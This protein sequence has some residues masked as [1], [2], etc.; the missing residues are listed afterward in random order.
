M[1]PIQTIE[2]LLGLLRRR[3]VMIAAI[4]V[5]GMIV[6]VLM[7]LNRPKTYETGAVLQVQLPVVATEDPAAV[8]ARTAQ[9]LQ[10]IEQRL[11]T[12]ENLIAIIER[13]D[14]FSDAPGLSISQKVAALRNSIGFQSVASAAQ[15][16]FGAPQRV[17][18]LII[19]A[20]LGDPDKAARLANDLA[21][22]VL[23]MSSARQASRAQETLRF[24]M[25]EDQRTGAAITALE[26][27]IT[28]FKNA[29]ADALPGS[30]E[31]RR[32]A[33]TALDTDLRAL[34]QARAALAGEKTAI[35]KKQTLRETDRRRLEEIASEAGVLDTQRAAL[36]TQRAELV[37]A[38]A[39]Q[40]EV[41]RELAGFERQLTQLQAQSDV[42][43]ARLAEAETNLRLEE[44]QQG[45]HFS[46]LE[47][48][49]IPEYA[50]SGG[51][52]KIAA[53]GTIAS[54]G[55]A[56]GLAFLLDLLF[57]VI[58]TS[59]QMEREL[60]LRP[61]VAIPDIRFRNSGKHWPKLPQ[62][63]TKV[64]EMAREA[65]KAAYIGGGVVLFLMGTMLAMA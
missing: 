57:P 13:H 38:L 17:S 5:V 14:L 24:Y 25:A 4:V 19:T 30:A 42:I 22:G 56:L 29:N 52:K 11:T 2:D 55:L 48:A 60:D 54:L 1:G 33:L 31:S 6:S 7:G 10:T 23:D 12:R 43:T 39:R 65:P 34:E 21:Q 45:E 62:V 15:P 64:V 18:A 32:S 49:I 63:A 58:R 27:Q 46:L 3:R 44:L 51:G 16:G 36:D 26:A 50:A 9:M 35:E 37:A 28:A 20:R 40:P 59:S 41:D 8:G 47:R 61:V 53:A